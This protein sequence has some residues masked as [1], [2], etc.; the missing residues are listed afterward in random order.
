MNLAMR[1]AIS[2]IQGR[3]WKRPD[4][5]GRWNTKAVVKRAPQCTKYTPT[6]PSKRTKAR[7]AG[8]QRGGKRNG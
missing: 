2:A 3:H 7:R 5:K 6:G 1:R 8:R 4:S